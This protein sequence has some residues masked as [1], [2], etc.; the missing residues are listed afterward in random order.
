LEQ[1]PSAPEQRPFAQEQRPSVPEGSCERKLWL[2]AP[3]LFVAWLPALFA[4][5][6]GFF[7]YDAVGQLPQA[8][9]DEVAYSTHHP[10]LHTLIMGK[11]MKFGY[12]ISGGD[13][14]VGLLLH[15]LFQMAV[16]AVVFA[17]LMQFVWRVCSKKWLVW[18]A[19]AY[20]ALFPTIA[21]FTLSTT[22]DVLYSLT[23]LLCVLQTYEMYRGPKAFFA[24]KVRVVLFAGSC[25]LMSLLRNNGIYVL[26]FMLAATLVFFREEKKRFFLLYLCI[27]T[28]CL[29]TNKGLASALH[30]TSGSSVEALS[31]PIQQIARV[32]AE[33]GEAG[34][35]EEE[36]ANLYRVA[37]PEI[38]E[39]YSPVSADPIKNTMYYE[40]VEQDAG[41]YL[42]L[43]L[44]LALRY[45]GEYL[46]ALLDNTYQAWYP[47]TLV[48]DDVKEHNLYYFDTQMRGGFLFREPHLEPLYRFYESIAAEDGYGQIPVLRLLFSMGTYL[49]LGLIT[50][51]FGIYARK[52]GVI[53]AMLMVFAYCA[54]ALLGP[55][56]LVRYYLIL[57]Y[58]LPVMIAFLFAGGERENNP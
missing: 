49:W 19:F 4:C 33:R 1:R 21:L 56:A 5:Y 38:L 31:I 18:A 12:Q 23:L 37:P 51:F 15:S 47:L 35:R 50:L 41:T 52:K 36:L 3:A 9:Y 24:K 2:L 17:A 57:Y 14:Q 42:K 45:P 58:G 20:Y 39:Q 54:T 28:L 40:V 8:L 11:I 44:S 7:N 53:W 32:Y 55:I 30:A 10:L 46:A 27:V 16:C 43:W 22:K 48:V 29:V 6:P 25:L 26:L 13:L 34:F